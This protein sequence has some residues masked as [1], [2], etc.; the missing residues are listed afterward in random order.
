MGKTISFPIKVD[1]LGE[2]EALVTGL[3]NV[4]K[5]VDDVSRTTSTVKMT[6][7]AEK[8]NLRTQ[9]AA[10][11]IPGVYGK[12]GAEEYSG[13][14]PTSG[15]SKDAAGG[16]GFAGVTSAILVANAIKNMIKESQT[17]SK[18][19]G[20]VSKLL[21]TLVDLVLLPFLPI[22]VFAMMGLASSIVTA[23]TLWK[24]LTS[25]LGT[26][27]SL[28]V[29]GTGLILALLAGAII[30]GTVQ[31]VVAAAS[32]ALYAWLTATVGPTITAS[33]AFVSALVGS[34]AAW[35]YALFGITVG[36]FVLAVTVGFF[37]GTAVVKLLEM[38]GVMQQISDLGKIF[39]ESDWF[40]PLTLLLWPFYKA[41]EQVADILNF[42]WGIGSQI[43]GIKMPTF[44]TTNK[45]NEMILGGTYDPEIMDRL[46]KKYGSDVSY[47]GGAYWHEGKKLT[48]FAQGGVVPGTGA[49][50]AVVHGGETITPPGKSVG[51]TYNF[52]GYDD[53]GLQAKVKNIL[54]SE[55]TRYTQ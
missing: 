36:G 3:K 40:G 35:F 16:I 46:R 19:L 5:A 42:I 50:L 32:A 8:A 39:R 27:L 10:M 33:V 22:L 31:L 1:G 13:Y 18:F 28:I 51:N 41:L 25:A 47:A 30:Y 29:L 24:K 54:R 44:L 48:E 38:W 14:R 52:Y 37:I 34:F 11:R 17:V 43:T 20:T 6:S 4:K 15:K 45:I 55:G 26:P 53:A 49:R 23:G 9:A 12:G 21:G 7:A 2:L